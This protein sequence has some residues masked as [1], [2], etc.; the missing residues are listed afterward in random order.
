MIVDGKGNGPWSNTTAL[1]PGNA[2]AIGA[3]AYTANNAAHHFI[4]EV[5]IARI[6]DS[7]KTLE[8]VTARYNELKPTIEALNA[9]E[10]PVLTANTLTP[11]VDL[12]FSN[13]ENGAPKAIDTVSNSP[14]AVE[15]VGNGISVANGVA[16]F[17]LTVTDGY[18]QA[19]NF[20]V[21]YS[22][23][24]DAINDGFTIEIIHKCRDFG[25]YWKAVFGNN[26]YSLK[27]SGAEKWTLWYVNNDGSW[28]FL[29]NS[30]M[31][32]TDGVYYH[33]VYVYD[34]ENNVY[35]LRTNGIIDGNHAW[36]QHVDTDYVMVGAAP[37]YDAKKPHNY[38][39]GEIAMFRIYDEPAN[40]FAAK[41]LYNAAKAQ[42]D[43]LNQ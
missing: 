39:Q 32:K 5:A 43:A 21:D 30:V 18:T 34:R 42:V 10:S 24:K 40:A 16:S 7:A 6:Y 38:W 4:G 29:E 2:L 41:E 15:Q 37:D 23:I 3:I 11:L 31:K 36:T 14:V 20:K 25:G 28:K 26:G 17:N 8:E 13:D 33:S 9:A 22:A 12:T 35:S 27:D 1:N 19:G